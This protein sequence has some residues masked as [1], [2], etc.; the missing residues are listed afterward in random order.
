M[1]R[2]P[3]PAILPKESPSSYGDLLDKILHYNPKKRIRSNE[4]INHP[5]F[6]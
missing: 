4:I 2:I 5:F 3:I 1:E 6:A